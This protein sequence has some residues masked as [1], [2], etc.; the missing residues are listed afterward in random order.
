MV[1]SNILAEN[2]SLKSKPIQENDSD[3]ILEID[4]IDEVNIVVYRVIY[5]CTCPIHVKLMNLI[6]SIHG[7]FYV[8]LGIYIIHVS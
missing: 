7:S 1:F 3:I 4:E 8:Y 6:H 5:I 2:N